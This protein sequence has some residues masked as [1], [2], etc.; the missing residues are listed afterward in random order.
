MHSWKR[1]FTVV[2][3]LAIR[4]PSHVS[5][6]LG[7][8]IAT[9][10]SGTATDGVFLT[11]DELRLTLVKLSSVH[12]APTAGGATEVILDE[13]AVLSVVILTTGV[14]LVR[15]ALSV[16]QIRIHLRIVH[17]L[18]HLWSLIS[19]VSIILNEFIS[20]LIK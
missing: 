14:S 16:L 10:C 18:K 6:S 5:T 3:L 1:L 12:L 20:S 7:V 9:E 19:T 11:L 13:D 4:L 17:V 2:D 8:G 15:L